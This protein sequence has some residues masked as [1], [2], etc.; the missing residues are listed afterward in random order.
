MIKSTGRTPSEHY[1]AKLCEHTFLSL[2]SYPNVFSDRGHKNGKGHNKEVCDLLVVFGDDVIIF[3]VKS[4]E[5]KDTGNVKRD[6]SRWHKRA[7]AKSEK[8]IYGA[9]RCM[10]N[11]PDRLFTDPNC[12]HPFPILLPLADRRRVHRIVVAL[13][14]REACKKFY[15]GGS[16]SL[17]LRT[18][19]AGLQDQPPEDPALFPFTVGHTDPRKGYVHAFDDVTLDIIMGELDTVSDFCAY[20]NKKENLVRSKGTVFAG[21]EEELLAFYLRHINDEGEHDF[22][23]PDEVDFI[24]VDEGFWERRIKN[25]QYLR[26]KKADKVSYF[27]D[28]IIEAF[29][30][31]AARGAVEFDG[32]F[33]QTEYERAI[34][35][36]ATLNRVERRALSKGLLQLIE[37]TRPKQSG[38]RGVVWGKGG[39]LAFA[40]LVMPPRKDRRHEEYRIVRRNLLDAYCCGLKLQNKS[41]KQ[42]IGIAMEPGGFGKGRSVDLLYRDVTVWTAEDDQA[43]R[44]DR[45]RL[46]I[47]TRVT[48]THFREKE[49]PEAR[50]YAPVGPLVDDRV[51]AQSLNR[52]QRRRRA[53]LRRRSE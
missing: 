50:V 31:E 43:A 25:A 44:G 42:V 49:Y 3:S 30:R 4:C 45:E 8:Q 5:F 34:R 47:L 33:D 27:W 19:L 52:Y 17:R 48:Q 18:S 29:N 41:L 24:L 39:D 6:W 1:L 11:H 26:K 15:G 2:W 36:L 7:I 14:A 10:Q 21:G 35:V 37:Q 46:G 16:G 38:F 28:Y 22:D 32:E 40:F 20:L 23:V 9:E 51:R 13:G 53:A 12:I